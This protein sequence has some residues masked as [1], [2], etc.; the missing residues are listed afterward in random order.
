MQIVKL[1]GLG[2]V[3]I[4]S[5]AWPI[6]PVY[7]IDNYV[8]EC[9]DSLLLQ[10]ESDTEILLVDDG[11][12]DSSSAIMNEYAS[13]DSRVILMSQENK[14]AGTARNL[15]MTKAQGEYYVFWDCDD[16]FELNALE[17]LYNRAKETDVSLR[18]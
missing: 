12:T 13:K 9:I 2:L 10:L 3:T 5:G 6:I 16:I 8:S 7:N 15:G 14:F 1:T 11:S 17:V 18:M 4:L